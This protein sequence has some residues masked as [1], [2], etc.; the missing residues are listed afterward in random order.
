MV[1]TNV[2]KKI[3]ILSAN[4]FTFDIRLFLKMNKC[5][6][7][8]GSNLGDSQKQLNIAIDKIT[9]KIGTIVKRSSLYQTAAWG[10]TDQPDFLNQ[11]IL[12]ATP[13]DAPTVMEIILSIES[14]MGRH[15][16]ERNA[17][18]IVDIDILFFN[19]L[20]IDQPH[21]H[22]PHPRLQDRRFVLEPM[23]ELDPDL[24]HPVLHKTIHQL[25]RVCPDPLTVKKFES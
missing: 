5:Y 8:L 9:T 11:A 2:S 22:I 24:F 1:K 6:L 3:K 18:R 13:F 4:K 15:R 20:I 25:L 16:T 10:K 14:D 12:T 21:L 17:P 7:L 23:N 19:D